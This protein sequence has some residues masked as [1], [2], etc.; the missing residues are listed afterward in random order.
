MLDAVL[1]ALG[2]SVRREMLVLLLEAHGAG[3]DDLSV[4]AV[5]RAL[6]IDRFS[7][8]RHLNVLT[9]CELVCAARRSTARVHRVNLVALAELDD[10]L[11]PFLHALDTQIIEGG[12]PAD[13]GPRQ[14]VEHA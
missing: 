6:D 11:Y 9:E 5:A 12:S 2:N 10:W 3:Q 7:A 14:P 1:T 4:G 13:E 8:S